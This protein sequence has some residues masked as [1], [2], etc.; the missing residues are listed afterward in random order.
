MADRILNR[1]LAAAAAVLFSVSASAIV[2]WDE[3]VNGDLSTDPFAPTVVN[4]GLGTNTVIGSMSTPNDTRDYLTFTIGA[5]QLLTGIILQQY[6][7]LDVGGPGNRGFF[8]ISAGPTS[9]IPG[10][11]TSGSFLSGAHLDPFGAGTD[12][13]TILQTNQLTGTGITSPLT[14][15]TYTFL[16]QQTGPQLTGYTFD[17]QVA[18]VPI[19]A[20]VWLF[21]TGLLALFGAR[22][23]SA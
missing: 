5:G 15:G 22:R 2:V 4:F 12:L 17:F 20:A 11:G 3:G 9:A 23:R 19:P 6:D 1:L 16:V 18:E 14:A 7:D 10:G 21:A 13:L 8:A